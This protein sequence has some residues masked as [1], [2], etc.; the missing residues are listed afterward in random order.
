M[1]S[2]FEL[3]TLTK[4]YTVVTQGICSIA[5]EVK[6]DFFSFF[7]RKQEAAAEAA[8]KKAELDA[9]VAN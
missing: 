9:K 4:K 2:I 7:R 1:K 5:I 3:L 8:R 6:F